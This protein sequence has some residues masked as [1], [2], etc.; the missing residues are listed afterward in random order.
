[1]YNI[2]V[3]DDEKEILSILKEFLSKKGYNV[4]VTAE[5]DEAIKLIKAKSDLDLIIL[6]IRMPK[7]KGTE[8]LQ[9]MKDSGIEV[10]FI[11]LSG[12]IGLQEQ[13]DTLNKMGYGSCDVLNKPVD[14]AKL[15]E[16]VEKKLPK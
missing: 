5:G 13:I 11:I 3:V 12:S 10:P 1:M 4:I 9:T 16:L 8:V 7:V 14:F 2:L 6:D 15:L